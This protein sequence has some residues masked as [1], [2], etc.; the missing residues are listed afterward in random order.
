MPGDLKGLSSV[1][2]R[3]GQGQAQVP[4]VGSEPWESHQLL[5]SQQSSGQWK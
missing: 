3:V 4:T 5:Y 1:S 2:V